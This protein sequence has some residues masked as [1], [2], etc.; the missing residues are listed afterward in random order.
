MEEQSQL[1][2]RLSARHQID[3]IWIR[4]KDL[5]TLGVFHSLC[6]TRDC[7]SSPSVRA[8]VAPNHPPTHLRKYKVPHAPRMS[9]QT[10]P[11]GWPLAGHRFPME[12]VFCLGCTKVVMPGTNFL[13]CQNVQVLSSS[14]F[15]LPNFKNFHTSFVFFYR[16]IL[17]C[18]KRL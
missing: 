7:F 18:F 8:S 5:P 16:L 2:C 17:L 13:H 15:S 4:P 12:G 14:H 3:L 9:L 11:Q 10:A 1:K 6:G